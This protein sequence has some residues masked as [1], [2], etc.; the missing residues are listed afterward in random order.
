MWHAAHHWLAHELISL[1]RAITCGISTQMVCMC[2]Y[3][4]CTVSATIRVGG[5]AVDGCMHG[6]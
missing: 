2:M 1:T 5:F 6:L 3:D 4:M